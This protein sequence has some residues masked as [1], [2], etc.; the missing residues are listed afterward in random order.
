MSDEELI[1]FA[2]KK[3]P[4][5]IRAVAFADAQQLSTRWVYDEIT[6]EA[7]VAH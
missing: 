7:M 3:D 1:T 6:S 4:Q 5:R 2:K